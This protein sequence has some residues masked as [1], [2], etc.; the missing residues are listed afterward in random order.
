MILP[1]KNEANFGYF[2][3]NVTAKESIDGGLGVVRRQKIMKSYN[4]ALDPFGQ[5]L[6]DYW[7]GNES[8]MLIHE[9]KTGE[10]KPLPVSVFF[11]SHGKFLPTD[12]VFEY[13]RGH[14]LV[15]GAGIG[16][17][18]LEL[19]NRGYEVTAID[20]CPQAVQ[21]MKEL[22]IKDV[23]QQNFM[24]FEDESFDTLCVLGHNI[25]HVRNLKR[26]KRITPQMRNAFETRRPD[27]G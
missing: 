5:A 20:I 9:F 3:K 22:G 12:N 14:I 10:K 4:S 25:W 15:V 18:A 26:N 24:Q 23:R 7:R 8:A 27:I 17:H 2:W 16:V 21:I 19:E 1:K 6:L 13:C 11:R